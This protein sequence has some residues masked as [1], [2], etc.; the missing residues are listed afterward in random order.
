MYKSTQ[1]SSW[2][3]QLN[4]ICLMQYVLFI[5]GFILHM[6][7]HDSITWPNMYTVTGNTLHINSQL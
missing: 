4:A 3:M 6:T 2:T 5:S 7:W 1:F